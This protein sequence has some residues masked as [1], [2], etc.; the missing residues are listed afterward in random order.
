MGGYLRVVQ[1]GTS[2]DFP[3]QISARDLRDKP[4]ARKENPMRLAVFGATGRTGKELVEQALAA[5][6]EVVAYA[7]NPS[8]LGITHENLTIVQGVLSDRE[9]IERAITSADAVISVLGPRGGSK[10]KPLTQGMQNIVA[11]MDKQA[12][13]RLIISSTLSV[14]DQND[15][16]EFRAGALVFLVKHIMHAAYEEIVS[17]AE[18]VR[19]SDLDWTIVR[20]AML[21]NKAKSGKVRAGYLGRGE[22]GTWIS[23]A[24]IAGFILQEMQDKKYV[25]QA[26]AISN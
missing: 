21:D 13:R 5:G 26:I 6:N 12:V 25:R 20:L 8:R 18:T 3:E 14:K 23:R 19:A 15:M 17:V 2:R 7:R 22:V 10:D 11:A 24:D 1:D 16:P 9:L 4:K